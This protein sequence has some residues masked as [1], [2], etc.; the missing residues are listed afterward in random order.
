MQ[1]VSNDGRRLTNLSGHF[2]DNEAVI[3]ELLEHVLLEGPHG[4]GDEA[5]IDVDDLDILH[6]EVYRIHGALDVFVNLLLRKR[7]LNPGLLQIGVA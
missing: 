4:K 6:C 3:M 7:Y 2:A 5:L 1:Q